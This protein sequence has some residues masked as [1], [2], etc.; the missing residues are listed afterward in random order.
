MKSKDIHSKKSVFKSILEKSEWNYSVSLDDSNRV[1][2]IIESIKK[3]SQTSLILTVSNGAEV[4]LFENDE[5]LSL[6]G[7]LNG[8]NL[9]K[10][11]E[12]NKEFVN[13]LKN[14]FPGFIMSFKKQWD[15]K[16]R[17]NLWSLLRRA[18]NNLPRE[19]NR[20]YFKNNQM[21]LLFEFGQIEIS[22]TIG[23]KSKYSVFDI[24]YFEGQST[25]KKI[26]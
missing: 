19:P 20:I 17:T 3:I 5:G 11:V 23:I 18:H 22:Y 2:G 6:R 13:F 9:T 21:T 16:K 24:L 14:Y 25:H 4:K 15:G 10:K 8:A 26:N 12:H 7:N 1:F